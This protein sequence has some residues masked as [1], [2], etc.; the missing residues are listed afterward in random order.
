MPGDR[1]PRNDT[2]ATVVE[3]TRAPAAVLV[4]TSPD[5]D[6]RGALEAMAGALTAAPRGYYRVAP[7]AWRDAGTLAPVAESGVREAMARAS[8]LV[9][10]GDTPLF[11]SPG[12][13]GRGALVLMVPGEAG[14]EWRAHAQGVSPLSPSLA[15][16]PW[17]SEPPIDLPAT[18][19][20]G[21]W[22]PHVTNA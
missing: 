1:E 21:E 6:A 20:R 5:P 2:V 13:L 4:S 7:G 17:D 19:P 18:S 15:G 9:L 11:G 3:V 16:V 14:A 10:H 22:T 12:A 8:L